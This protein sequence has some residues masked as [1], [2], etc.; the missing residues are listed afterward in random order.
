MVNRIIRYLIAFIITGIGLGILW[1]LIEPIIWW[2]NL[3]EIR[4]Y[5]RLFLLMSAINTFAVLRLY[6]SIVQNTRFSIK[7]REAMTKFQQTIPG[8]ERSVKSM[9]SALNNA[10]T[11]IGNLTKGITDNTDKINTLNDKLKGMR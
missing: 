3:S 4:L 9:E 11:S 6:N 8:I 2:D 1:L 5:I 10:K 7:L